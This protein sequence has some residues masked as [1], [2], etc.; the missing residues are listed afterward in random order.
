MTLVTHGTDTTLSTNTVDW[1]NGYSKLVVSVWISEKAGIPQLCPVSEGGVGS[2][3][4]SKLES[5]GLGGKS[6]MRLA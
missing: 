1:L 5:L 4:P 6:S 2:A 3:F